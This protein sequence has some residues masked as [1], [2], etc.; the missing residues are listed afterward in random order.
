MGNIVDAAFG[1]SGVHFNET[2]NIRT[3]YFV[4]LPVRIGSLSE[5]T[6]NLVEHT[7]LSLVNV[8]QHRFAFVLGGLVVMLQNVNSLVINIMQTVNRFHYL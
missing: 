2:L 4:Q 1:R 5:Q 7:Q 8:A 6:R 3:P